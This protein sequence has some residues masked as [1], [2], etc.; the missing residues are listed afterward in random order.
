MAEEYEFRLIGADGS[1]DCEPD[2]NAGGDITGV[3]A[4]TGMTGGGTGGDVTISDTSIRNHPG[5][6]IYADSQYTRPTR[7]N[8]TYAN[9]ALGDIGP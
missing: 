8:V 4:G 3:T 6:G 2:D 9:N 7:V 1:V 5:Y